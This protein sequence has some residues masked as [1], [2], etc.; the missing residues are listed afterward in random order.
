MNYDRPHIRG[1]KA[2]IP[3]EQPKD[4][5]VIKLN[6]NENPYPPAPAVMEVLRNIDPQQLRRYPQPFADDF[7]RA[8]ADLHGVAPE[9]IIAT[10]GGDELLRLVISCFVAPGQSIGVTEP[11][12][13]LYPVLAQIHEA[14]MFAVELGEQW[15]IPQGFAEQLNRQQI[16]LALVVNPHAPSGR[17]TP[18]QRLAEL[19]EQF[20]G[21]LLIDE[22]YVDFVDPELNYS[23]LPLVRNR[24]NVIILR[25]LSKGYSLAGLRYGYGVGSETLIAALHKIR[26]SYNK[27]AI[28]QGMA[29]EALR[30]Q[31]YAAQTWRD[32]RS[33]RSR[34]AAELLRRGLSAPP[35]QANFLLVSV[36]EDQC[37]GAEALYLALKQRDILVR[38][39]DQ[40]RLRDKLRITIGTA[41]ENSAL[42][43]A[44]DAIADS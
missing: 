10:N 32:V 30:Q 5:P 18:A 34:L 23:T 22:A 35:S 24:D 44:I 33:E 19:A 14:G 37:G 3:G 6:T 12:Y 8:A 39:F 1:L 43:T 31:E 11:S 36:P 21:V 40:P 9:N 13:S 26:D 28:A 20:N 17:L 41:E 16:P 15:E 7:R 42:L 38:W 4:R 2:Y 27:D 25:T 29:V